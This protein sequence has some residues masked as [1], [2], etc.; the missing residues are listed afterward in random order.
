MTEKIDR[1]FKRKQ[2]QYL[3]E[4]VSDDLEFRIRAAAHGAISAARDL[5]VLEGEPEDLALSIA[6]YARQKLQAAWKNE[7]KVEH[8]DETVVDPQEEVTL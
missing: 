3:F 5:Q 7:V 6:K 1:R 8:F 2:Q 4:V